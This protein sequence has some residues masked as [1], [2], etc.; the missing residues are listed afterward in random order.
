[1]QALLLQRAVGSPL[2]DVADR[3]DGWEAD[4]G[5]VFLDDGQVG[6]SLGLFTTRVGKENQVRPNSSVNEL[7]EHRCGIDTEPVSNNQGALRIGT[8]P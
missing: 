3:D 2:G 7:H 5:Q 1:M 8:H 6:I 4:T